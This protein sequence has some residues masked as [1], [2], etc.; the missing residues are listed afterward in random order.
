VLGPEHPETLISLNNLANLL[1]SR[2]D[3]AGAEPLYR[4][5]LET[6][7]RVLGRRHPNT[8]MSLFNFALHRARSGD[9]ERAETLA[10]SAFAGYLEAV[11]AKHP[12]TAATERLLK[13]ISAMKRAAQSTGPKRNRKKKLVSA[14]T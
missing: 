5:A 6:N 10:R 8:L 7:E 2:G 14:G 13:E 11:G 3:F 9:F 12:D 1:V 4:R